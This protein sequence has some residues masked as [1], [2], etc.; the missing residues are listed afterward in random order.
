MFVFR[1]LRDTLFGKN[2]QELM[3]SGMKQGFLSIF[4]AAMLDY[5]AVYLETR[6]KHEFTHL[7]MFSA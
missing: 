4:L 2:L 6:V 1:F 3:N 7:E 5:G